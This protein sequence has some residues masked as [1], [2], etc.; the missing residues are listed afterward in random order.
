[1][2]VNDT[3]PVAVDD[4]ASTSKGT[5]VDINVLGN[6][7]DADGDALSISGTPTAL[8]GTVSVNGD[9]TLHYTPN[10]GY[11]G[12][13]TISYTVTDGTL[14][15]GGQVAVTVNDTA[16]VAVDDTASTSKGAAVDINVLGNDTDADGDTLSISG[17]PTALHGTV[18]VNGDGTLHYTPNAGF[19]GSD[20]ISYTVTDGTL[21]DTAQWR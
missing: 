2:T 6:D 10:A 7:T 13:D 19:S 8:H 1:M 20:T 4:T 17:T 14:S 12:A 11:T 18:S 5:A 3:A 15:D 9:G 16:P 21:S